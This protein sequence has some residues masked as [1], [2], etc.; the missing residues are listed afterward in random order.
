[1]NKPPLI[2]MPTIIADLRAGEESSDPDH[3]GLRVRRANVAQASY[4]PVS[5]V[6]CSV[7]S[8]KTYIGLL[9]R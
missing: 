4:C 9:S 7:L 6:T 8:T 5:W 3:P 1:M 2:L